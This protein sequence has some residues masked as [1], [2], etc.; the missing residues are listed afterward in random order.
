MGR[1]FPKSELLPLFVAKWKLPAHAQGLPL[2]PDHQWDP[3]PRALQE[4]GAFVEHTQLR[5]GLRFVPTKEECPTASHMQRYGLKQHSKALNEQLAFT[6][7]F[8][9][10]N[11]YIG[12]FKKKPQVKDFSK[13]C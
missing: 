2:C 13:D 6:H 7:C 5:A 8:S 3:L 4:P 10:V 12:I 11:T 9:S 1:T